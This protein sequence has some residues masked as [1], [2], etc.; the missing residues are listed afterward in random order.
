MAKKPLWPSLCYRDDIFL[1]WLRENIEILAELSVSRWI[2]EL[3]TSKIQVTNITRPNLLCWLG[4]E[5][6]SYAET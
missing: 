2:F 3:G 5:K 6:V 4:S 1:E